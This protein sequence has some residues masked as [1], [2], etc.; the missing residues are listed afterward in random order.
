MVERNTQVISTDAPTQ[1]P[2]TNSPTQT[3]TPDRQPPEQSGRTNCKSD[4]TPVPSNDF[5]RMMRKYQRDMK[6]LPLLM[7]WQEYEI[8]RGKVY[9]DKGTLIYLKQKVVDSMIVEMAGDQLRTL[10]EFL[11]GNGH[12]IKGMHIFGELEESKTYDVGL[13]A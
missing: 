4:K 1:Q 8:I 2:S 13:F 7:T 9:L 6:Q 12:K 11:D 10:L 5:L 3:K